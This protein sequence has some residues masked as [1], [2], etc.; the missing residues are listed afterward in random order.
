MWMVHTMQ[1]MQKIGEIMM[2]DDVQY[3]HDA[4]DETTIETTLDNIR[5]TPRLAVEPFL[6]LFQARIEVN[7]DGYQV[8]CINAADQLKQLG[9]ERGFILYSCGAQLPTITCL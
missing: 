1:L 6:S 2:V 8:V 9:V 3:N 7:R 4:S 5:M